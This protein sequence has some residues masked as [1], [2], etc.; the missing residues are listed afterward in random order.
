VSDG[1][2]SDGS[3]RDQERKAEEDCLELRIDVNKGWHGGI[4]WAVA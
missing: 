2:E 4:N 3:G 1:S